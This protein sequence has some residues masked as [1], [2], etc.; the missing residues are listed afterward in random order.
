MRKTSLQLPRRPNIGTV[1]HEGSKPWGKAGL[2]NFTISLQ[3]PGNI[4]SS[5]AIS[6][7]KVRN[8]NGVMLIWTLYNSSP[9]PNPCS[10]RQLLCVLLGTGGGTDQ[11]TDSTST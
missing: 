9:T 7:L 2:L 11:A 4:A 10:Y 1:E 8:Q 3:P 5:H 6:N